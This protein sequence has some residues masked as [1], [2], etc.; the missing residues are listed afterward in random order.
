MRD[1][2]LQ[3]YL[4]TH[5]LSG[6]KADAILARTSSDGKIKKRKKKFRN[7]APESSSSATGIIIKDD[8]ESWKIGHGNEDGDDDATTPQI[9]GG[10]ESRSRKAFRKI[11]G[12]RHIDESTVEG[13]GSSTQAP[14]AEASAEEPLAFKAGLRT[15]EEMKAARLA[16]EER[17]R[18]EVASDPNKP[19]ALSTPQPDSVSDEDEETRKAQETVYRDSTGRVIDIHEQEKHERALEQQRL[20]KEKERATW[21]QGLVQK[22]ARA[23]AAA[24]LASAQSQSVTRRATD[25]EYNNHFRSQIHADDPALAFLTKKRLAGPQK[26]NYKGPYPPN[27]FHIAPGYRWDGVDRGNGFERALVERKQQLANREREARAWGQSDM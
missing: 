22:Q 3:A 17:R 10:G 4:A 2:K 14:S 20:Q 11:G 16:R 1:P 27:R 6:P 23:E 7:D 5:Y 13:E 26:P 15:K 21:G 19:S 9:V 18:R 24:Q 8:D 25:A 12:F